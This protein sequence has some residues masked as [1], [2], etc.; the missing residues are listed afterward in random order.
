[1]TF[2][3]AL[4][5]GLVA[6]AHCVGMCGGVQAVL[7][8]PQRAQTFVMRTPKQQ[9]ANL[10]ALN[11]GRVSTYL[12]AGLVISL[13]GAGVILQINIPELI[14]A[15][16]IGTGLILIALGMQLLLRKQRPFHFIEAIGAR[17]WRLAEPKIN[18]SK[19]GLFCAYRNGLLWGLLPCG[20]VYGVLLST[21]FIQPASSGALIMLGFGL[22]TLP[23]L[24]LSGH[25]L[26]KFRSVVNAKWV[27]FGAALFFIFGGLLVASA[28]YWA[29]TSF[30]KH[31][32]M[33]LNTM[34]CIS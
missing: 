21:V 27:Q 16:R 24:L 7:H 5:L 12:L 8:S 22:G 15:A 9:W 4:L 2:W 34:F 30:V 18:H 31:Y 26:Q 13:V 19:P 14:Q 10:L 17:I 33:L 6:S 28:P 1:M 23:A 20:L 25:L 32:P 29:D 3:S 11:I